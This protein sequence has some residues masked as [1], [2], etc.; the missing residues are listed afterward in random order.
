MLKA[1]EDFARGCG[2]AADKETLGA[3]RFQN[4]RASRPEVNVVAG[5]R[6]RSLILDGL[7]RSA[8]EIKIATVEKGFIRNI[9]GR[10][11]ES[12]RINNTAWAD[13][14]AV[15]IDEIDL[16]VRRKISENR[17]GIARDDTIQC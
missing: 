4:H 10:S 17:R 2:G 7:P 3:G 11:Q 13:Q 6:D 8:C 14:N 1:C 15:W 9:E 16:S 5:S 12:V